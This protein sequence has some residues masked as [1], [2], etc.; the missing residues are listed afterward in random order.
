MSAVIHQFIVHQLLVKSEQK[1]TLLPREACIEVTP[2]IETLVAQI[3]H[4]FN[5]KPSKGI[6]KFAAPED[7][8]AFIFEQALNQMLI[9]SESESSEETFQHFTQA[10]AQHL[11]ATMADM[12][13]VETGFLVFCRY[14]YLATDY[15]MVCLLNTQQHVH[16]DKQLE[17]TIS[18]HLDL[19]KMQLAARID[20]TQLSVQPEKARYISFIKGRM[21]R[22]VADF[23]MAFLG[24]EELLDIKQQNAQLLNSVDDYL[25]SEQLDVQEK[26]QHRD[27]VK[28]YY[29][30]KIASGDDIQLSELSAKLPSD[31]AEN[32]DFS[33]FV[34]ASETPIE[35]TF[36]PDRA[37]IKQLAKFSGQGGGVTLSFDRNLYGDKVKYDAH[38]DTL[39]IRGIPPNL[40]DQ[41]MRSEK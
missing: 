15:L 25:A 5:G 14:E 13:M 37:V 21:G 24:C 8:Q 4:A 10:A 27:T 40:K 3:N 29:K 9:G 23:F 34:Q 16:V 41:L 31:A 39:V 11:I 30:E 19:A 32:F 36:Q 28:E 2:S 7:E 35:D 18:E 33:Q 26:Q 17:L 1:L 12:Q 6:G 22:K 38:T 20:L